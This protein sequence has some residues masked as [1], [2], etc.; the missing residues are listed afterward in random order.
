MAEEKEKRV[1]TVCGKPLTGRQQRY[2]S[3][4]CREKAASIWRLENYTPVR[5]KQGVYREQTCI[6]CGKPF[7]GHIRSKRCP[8][9]KAERERYLK[10]KS[11]ERTRL[12]RTRKI[13]ST[14]FC[15]ACGEPY[16]VTSGIQRYCKKCAPIAVAENIRAKARER[17]A[18]YYKDETHRYEKTKARR[19]KVFDIK[20]CDICGLV[21]VPHGNREYCSK[22]CSDEALKRWRKT[23]ANGKRRNEA[24]KEIFR[25]CLI[26]NK[27]FAISNSNERYC[28]DACRKESEKAKQEARK[29]ARK[30]ILKTCPI[31]NKEFEVSE[32]HRRYC[33][34]ACSKEAIRRRKKQYKDRMRNKK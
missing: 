16:I 27:E 17:T 2:C 10:Q 5:G 28:S 25:K 29:E 8:T 14:D 33:S 3:A 31:C 19:T 1:C 9:C 20:A 18:E 21:F 13:G 12:G 30:A 7:Y 11:N 4:E 23:H 15:E 6:D 32:Q 22:D 34:D 26:C 24:K